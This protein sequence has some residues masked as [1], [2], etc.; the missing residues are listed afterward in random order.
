MRISSC[1][2]GLQQMPANV[3]I[4]QN[5][6]NKMNQHQDTKLIKYQYEILPWLCDAHNNFQQS[7]NCLEDL[8]SFVH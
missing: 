6:F 8:I 5:L 4:V 7:P 1:K 2:H 3:I